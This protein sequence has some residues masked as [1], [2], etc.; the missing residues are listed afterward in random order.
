[1]D[2]IFQT[3]SVNGVDYVR[4][5]SIPQNV[6]VPLENEAMRIV[7]VD[8]RGL[9]FVG[10]CSLDE[11]GEWLTIKD[12]MCVIYW[13]TTQHIAELVNGPTSKTRLGKAQT[14]RVRAENVVF[15]YDCVSG[16]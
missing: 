12:A 2:T 4:K 11:K 1:M 3:L 6:T 7:C 9:T 13:G 16:W 10:K 5:D 8:N 14:V 15:V